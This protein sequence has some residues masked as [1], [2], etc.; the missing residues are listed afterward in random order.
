MSRNPFGVQDVPERQRR[1]RHGFASG[2]RLT[3]SADDANA[4]RWND[5]GHS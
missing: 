5:A 4:E 1:G 2:V 3:G